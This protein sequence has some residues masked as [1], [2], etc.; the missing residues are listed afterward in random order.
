[1]P[2]AET[3]VDDAAQEFIESVAAEQE[4]THHVHSR[5][6]DCCQPSEE[7]EFVAAWGVSH[8]TLDSEMKEYEPRKGRCDSQDGSPPKPFRC[9]NACLIEHHQQI[10][11]VGLQPLDCSRPHRRL[12]L[13]R[14][15]SGISDQAGDSLFESVLIMVALKSI[16]HVGQG[17]PVRCALGKEEHLPFYF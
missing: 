6:S 7:P 12:S 13:V 3:R 17:S 2:G 9:A 14:P 4:P 1:V 11:I 10:V 5:E 16:C 15:P 8:V